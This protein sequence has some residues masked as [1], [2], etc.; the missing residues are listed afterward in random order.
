VKE[1]EEEVPVGEGGGGGRGGGREER[2]EGG[3]YG[4]GVGEGSRGYQL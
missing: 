2:A 1:G 4:A 3:K